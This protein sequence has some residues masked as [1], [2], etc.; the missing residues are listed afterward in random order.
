MD[1]LGVRSRK[2]EWQ[3][4]RFLLICKWIERWSEKIKEMEI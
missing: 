1:L 4:K 2:E 3:K